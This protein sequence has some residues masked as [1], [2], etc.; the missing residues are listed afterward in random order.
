MFKRTIK[1]LLAATAIGAVGCGA[2]EEEIA[3]TEGAVLGDAL[4]RHQ[5]HHV[6]GREGELRRDRE[7][8]GRSRTDLQ[9][10]E[11]RRLPRQ[12]RGRR[13]GPE[14]RAALRH[15]DQRRVRSAGRTGGSLRQLFGIG[16]FNVGGLNCN[17]GTDANPAPGAT[18]FAGRLTTPL[19]GARPRRLAARLGASTRSPAASRRRSAASSTASPSRSPTRPTRRSTSAARASAASAGRPACRT[20]LSSRRTRT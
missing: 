6:R 8:Y 4:R 12:R 18:I 3:S 5:R 10:A 13:R 16:G 15:A 2:P 9:R 14:H 19:F 20:W 1:I 17:S 11:L 7:R